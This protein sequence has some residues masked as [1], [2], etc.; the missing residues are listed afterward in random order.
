MLAGEVMSTG[1]ATVHTNAAIGTAIALMTA[2]YLSGL[3]VVDDHARLVGIL[4]EGDLL[5]RVEIGTTDRPRSAWLDLLLGSGRSAGDY[6]HT[7]SRHVGDLMT[8]EVAT[9]SEGTPIEDVISLMEQ[10]HVKRIPVVRDDE[11]VGVLSRIDLVRALGHA[12]DA[13]ATGETTDAAV[14]ERL[15]A[16]LQAER[17]FPARDITIAVKDGVVTLRG[18]ISDERARDAL[19]V[20]AENMAGVATVDDQLVWVD[21]A[22]AGL[23]F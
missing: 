4:T 17:W 18:I 23:M 21:P 20:A 3:P 1:V 19:R 15:Q 8:R 5:R 7:H 2:R 16:D 22:N 12:L 10:K 14:R 6:V 13:A 11:I 9:V